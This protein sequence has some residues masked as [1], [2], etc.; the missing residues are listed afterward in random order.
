MAAEINITNIIEIVS[1]AVA[2]VSVYVRMQVKQKEQEMKI[3]ALE[4]RATR[5]EQDDHDLNKKLDKIMEMLTDIKIELKEK[6][7]RP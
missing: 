4:Q 6:A 7:D 5:A 1:F 2:L 3:V